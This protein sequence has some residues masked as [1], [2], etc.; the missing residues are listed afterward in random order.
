MLQ[1]LRRAARR[2]INSSRA[3]SLVDV[4]RKGIFVDE[5]WFASFKSQQAVRRGEPI[6]WYTYAFIHFLEPRLRPDLKVFEYGCGNSTRWY[7]PRVASV[8]AVEHDEEWAGRVGPLLPPPSEV[9]LR[10]GDDAYVDAVRG[11]GPF[12]VVV[13]DGIEHLRP[14][15]AEAALG[16]LSDDGVIVWDNSDRVEFERGMESLRAA[17]FRQLPFKGLG[18]TS[19]TAWETSVVYRDRN[20]LGI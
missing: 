15:C 19:T 12:D 18:P 13:V 20:C 2:A 8:T 14:A 3:G 17:G 1:P 7:A 6:P 5:D 11:R 9:L 10:S 4:Y 16:E